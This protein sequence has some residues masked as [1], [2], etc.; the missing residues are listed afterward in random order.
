MEARNHQRVGTK[1]MNSVE[2]SCPRTGEGAPTIGRVLHGEFGRRLLAC[3]VHSL[4]ARPK[5][6]YAH[7]YQQQQLERKAGRP[8]SHTLGLQQ[9]QNAFKNA[10]IERRLQPTARCHSYHAVIRP[11]RNTTI[12][13]TEQKRCSPPVPRESS[14]SRRIKAAILHQHFWRHVIAMNSITVHQNIV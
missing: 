8:I 6:V 3:C 4:H 12:R 2:M 14:T 9:Q 5:V 11:N 10:T 7:T 13:R 1:T